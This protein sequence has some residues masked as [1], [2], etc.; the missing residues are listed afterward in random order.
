MSSQ[1]KS[2]DP[3]QI[4]V[5]GFLSAILIA[6]F[7]LYLP[8]FHEPNA[9]ITFGESLFTATSAITVTGLNVIDPGS[10][11][12]HWG[13]LLLI[14]F[15]QIGGLGFM[16]FGIWIFVL[17]G[18]KISLKQRLLMQE[19]TGHIHLQGI[20]RLALH[21]LWITL[22]FEI[23]GGLILAAIWQKTMGWPEAIFQGIFH[24]VSAFNNAGFSL[25]SNSLMDY[26]TNP[27]VNII[28]MALIL[29]GGIG[30]VVILEIINKKFSFKKL[31]LHTKV[32]LIANLALISIG[33]IFFFAIEFLNTKTIGTYGFGGKFITSLFQVVTT[34]TAGFNSIDIS[35]L[36]QA[37][38]FIFLIYMF[39]GAS[40]GSTGGGVKVTTFSVIWLTIR[41]VLRGKKHV[42][43][44]N[45]TLPFQLVLRSMVVLT[46]SLTVVII[47]SLIL[48]I[49]ET[50][51]P[52]L[53]I[54]FEATS[55]FGTVGLSTGLTPH[56]SQLG[57]VVIMITMFIGRL[58]PLTFGF[59]LAKKE[60]EEHFKY[61]EEK[62]MI[63]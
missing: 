8:V 12:N 41:A 57:R 3:T 30:F 54:L 52:F 29:L 46:L 22:G 55:A 14:I 49:T 51:V 62:L 37:T 58:G 48:D 59:A 7:L 63:G 20:V 53:D 27:L 32:T 33:L 34:R 26:A 10:T 1:K 17:L 35:G 23:T 11:F 5:I 16:T 28:I 42:T 31:S 4:L 39:I 25:F 40:S 15:I 6:A 56:L 21:L 18:R 60:E 44:F 19:N 45:R 36:R 43:I 61:P 47:S 9:N 24:A 13:E 2:L 50:G 38:L